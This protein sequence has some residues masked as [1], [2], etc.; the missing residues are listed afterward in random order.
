[1]S[2]R[3]VC[4]KKRRREAEDVP[5]TPALA[6]AP[7]AK[8]VPALAP[9]LTPADAPTE[10]PTPAE[11]PASTPRVRSSSSAG[12]AERSARAWRSSIKDDRARISRSVFLR[13]VEKLLETVWE[14]E[15]KRKGDVR[16]TLLE[17]GPVA[18]EVLGGERAGEGGG[19]KDEEGK[20]GNTGEEHLRREKR[21]VSRREER[22]KNDRTNRRGGKRR[23]G[24][25]KSGVEEVEVVRTEGNGSDTCG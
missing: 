20:G 14:A 25:V 1:M 22:W 16:G 6:P 4:S 18:N 8:P 19:G 23:G 7:T 17:R 13:G 21:R 11:T 3:V 15:V 9:A 24:E 10:A 12:G 2:V 5:L